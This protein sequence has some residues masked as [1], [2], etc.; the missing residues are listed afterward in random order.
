MPDEQPKTNAG[1]GTATSGITSVYLQGDDNAEIIETV[2]ARS[3]P[4]VPV[5]TSRPPLPG[6]MRWWRR[7]ARESQRAHAHGPDARPVVG[8][9]C[10]AAIAE[11]LARESRRE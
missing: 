6:T 10:P 8:R 3:A 9:H 1:S 4:M 2:H 11:L 7:V 5:A